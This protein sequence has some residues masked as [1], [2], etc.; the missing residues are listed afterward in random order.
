M[1]DGRRE[2]LTTELI[3]FALQDDI[4]AVALRLEQLGQDVLTGS[5]PTKG[6]NYDL[7]IPA[8][9]RPHP[10]HSRTVQLGGSPAGP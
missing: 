4:A 6:G 2:L 9:S 7:K 5:N 10:N 3:G 1:L 8:L